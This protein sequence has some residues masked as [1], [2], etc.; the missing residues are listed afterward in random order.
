MK[1]SHRR[2]FPGNLNIRSELWIKG[3]RAKY[4]KSVTGYCEYMYSRVIAYKNKK[5]NEDSKIAAECHELILMHASG[6]EMISTAKSLPKRIV[7]LRSVK[8]I[9]DVEMRLEMLLSQLPYTVTGAYEEDGVVKSAYDKY[10]GSVGYLM[11]LKEIFGLAAYCDRVLNGLYRSWESPADVAR[12]LSRLMEIK[13]FNTMTSLAM[14]STAFRNLDNV[15]E[16]RNPAKWRNSFMKCC[17]DSHQGLNDGLMQYITTFAD[18]LQE[19][20]NAEEILFD[21]KV[22]VGYDS[23]YAGDSQDI[24]D[25]VNTLKNMVSD[26]R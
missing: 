1:T 18:E 19:E 7:D 6:E 21:V 14:L 17:H 11:G 25:I 15:S 2:P 23:A 4:V 16:D 9:R 26:G 13:S 24:M 22:F 10:V 3:D 8:T 12:M 5:I 20:G